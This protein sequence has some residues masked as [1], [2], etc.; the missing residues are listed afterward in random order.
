M[1]LRKKGV[2]LIVVVAGLFFLLTLI[3][4]DKFAE[5]MLESAGTKIIGAKVDID[6]LDISLINSSMSWDRLQVTHPKHTMKNMIETG[7]VTLDFSFP[8]LLQG[9]YVIEEAT[10]SGIQTFTQRETDGKIE[11]KKQK[12]GQPGLVDKQITNLQNKVKSAPVFDIPKNLNKTSPKKLLDGISFS[13][14]SKVDS[15]KKHMSADFREWDEKIKKLKESDDIKK[16]ESQLKSLKIK[17]IKK[18]DD[19]KNELDRLNQLKKEIQKIQSNYTNESKEL[20]KFLKSLSSTDNTVQQWIESDFDKIKKLANIPDIS[21]LNVGQLLLGDYLMSYYQTYLR[22]SSYLQKYRKLTASDKPEK[23]KPPRRKGQ[24]IYF[25][26]PNIYPQFWLQQGHLSGETNNQFKISGSL[27]NITSQPILL[28]SPQL[29]EISGTRKDEAN[30][31]IRWIGS[32]SDSV[33]VDSLMV[34]ATKYPVRNLNTNSSIKYLPTQ[35]VK[36]NMNIRIQSVQVNDGLELNVVLQLVDPEFNF[37]QFAAKG[38]EQKI[39]NA[40]KSIFNSAQIMDFNINIRIKNGIQVSV[41]SN[42][43]RRVRSEINKMLGDEVRQYEKKLRAE[44]NKKLSPI[45]QD[46]GNYLKKHKQELEQNNKELAKLINEIESLRNEKKKEVEKE[47][48]KKGSDI[49]NKFFK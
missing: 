7:E 49:L 43:D 39:S 11:K 38:M 12:K 46:F 17:D 44:L 8:A 35:I 4:T 21:L 14:P 42:L 13:T 22:Y 25:I 24:N 2:V 27:E 5:N 26:A 36:A 47:I 48:K 40:I 45:Q 41:R 29:I 19:L 10:F 33:F 31:K 23:S 37:P 32:H 30:F 20:Q 1:I 28:K 34:T 6:G 9:K 18:I 3:I 15:L 16:V